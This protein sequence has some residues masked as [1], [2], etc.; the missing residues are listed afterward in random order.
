[1]TNIETTLF[2][3]NSDDTGMQKFTQPGVKEAQLTHVRELAFK[4]LEK[5][6]S[7]K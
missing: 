3:V 5:D 1:M 6:N 2:T 7:A 4:E